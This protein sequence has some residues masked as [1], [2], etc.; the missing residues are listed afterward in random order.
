MKDSSL[1]IFAKTLSAQF[2]NKE[3]AQRSPSKF[4]HINIYF[5][6]LPWPFRGRPAFY[7]E[8][9][10]DYDPWSPYRQG[11]HNLIEK[12]GLFI[13]N[14]YSIIGAERIAGAGFKRELLNDLKEESL[15]VR[16]GCAMH[17][18]KVNSYKFEGEVEPGNHCLIP[19]QGK[20]TYLKSH[21]LLDE[22]N[23]ICLDEGF[24]LET[25]QKIWGSNYGHLYFKKV[26]S[27]GCHLDEKWIN[28]K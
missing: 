18:K 27:L 24:D 26:L 17:F 23:W 3:Q 22:S 10:F 25:D 13:L 1:L 7:S 19:R 21:V 2:S 11:V 14:N 28:A 15:K 5:Q 16:D 9:S 4:A 20:L 12:N 6:P 8:Q